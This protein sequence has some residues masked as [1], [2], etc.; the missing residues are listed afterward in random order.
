MVNLKEEDQENIKEKKNGVFI[1]DTISIKKEPTPT[2]EAHDFGKSKTTG[3]VVGNLKNET[4]T[5]EKMTQE[6]SIHEKGIQEKVPQAK[7]NSRVCG[8]LFYESDN[9]K[10][11]SAR[12]GHSDSG[13][14]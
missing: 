14:R 11:H 12:R 9:E 1:V 13:I 3:N 8:Q 5:P 2:D 10:G 4:K 7:T 6:K